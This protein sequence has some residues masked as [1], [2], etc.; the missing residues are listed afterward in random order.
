MNDAEDPL[1][2]LRQ[3][4]AA[5]QLQ[6]E[7]LL[8]QPQ[9]RQEQLQP[10]PEV[11][12]VTIK[13]PPFWNNKPSLWFAQVE[14]QFTLA[15][16]TQE[17]T[18]FSYVIANLEQRFASEV[19]DLITTPPAIT[20]YTTLKTE[21][22]RRLSMSKEK[23][24]RQLLMEEKLGDR[25]PSQFLRHLRSLAGSTEVHDELL[26]TI[27]LQRLPIH[28]QA[29]LQTQADQVGLTTDKLATTADK[30]IEV[31]PA[32]APVATNLCA[33]AQAATS[34]PSG[35]NT[36]TKNIVQ[37]L[38]EM[39]RQLAA[40]QSQLYQL[41][42]Q[43]WHENALRSQPARFRSRSRSRHGSSRERKLNE[44]SSSSTADLCW[45]HRRFGDK[46]QKCEKPCK[47]LSANSNGSQ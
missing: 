7:Q 25:T 26:Q 38:D 21:L 11:H 23:R 24:I 2:Q 28:V 22:V 1:D 47:F 37:R 40:V 30:I 39:S 14:A 15:G 18:K 10:T 16:I 43:P 4:Y 33:A 44:N 8:Q 42:T 6:H 31:Q 20:P 17:V 3:Q 12:R 19:E 45:Y 32:T 36:D 13:L 5:L 29:I 35:L 27:W 41:K 9:Q 34:N 46:A